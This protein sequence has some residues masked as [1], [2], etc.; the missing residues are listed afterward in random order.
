MEHMPSHLF[1][2]PLVF[3]PE[4]VAAAVPKRLSESFSLRAARLGDS[5]EFIVAIACA[6]PTLL[7]VR[8]LVRAVSKVDSRHVAI[9]SPYLDGNMM[10]ALSCEG[11]AYIRDDGNVFLPFLG[12]AAS[13]VPQGRAAKPL[14]PHAQRIVLNVITGRWDGMSA[15]ELAETM[16]L[17]RSTITNCLAEIE[18]ILPSSISTEW[19]KRIVRNPGM[20][21]D[22]LLAEFEP[23]FVSPVRERKLLK[24]RGALDPLKRNGALLCG[25]SALP[26]YSD[27]AHDTGSLRLALYR[28]DIAAVMTETGEDWIEAN[29]FE[30]PDIIVEEWSYGI[31]GA[32]E[33]S[34]ASREFKMLDAIG[35]YAEMRGEGQDDVRLLDAVSQLREEACR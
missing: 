31:D 11:V 10:K 18:A 8:S 4:E 35:L 23:Y 19:R 33:A 14:S 17:S 2:L 6:R 9:Y 5:Q 7:T 25:E 20:S 29:W 28:K 32:S 22:E 1:S 26:Y 13:P 15:G 34:V 3:L 16:G 24:G 21:K 30:A 12:V 27:L